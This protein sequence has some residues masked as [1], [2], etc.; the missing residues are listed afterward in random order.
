MPASVSV[1]PSGRNWFFR[2]DF[3]E[4][5]CACL[6]LISEAL[7]GPGAKPTMG[8]KAVIG[9]VVRKRLLV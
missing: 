8:I 5:R 2:V 4:R 7:S 1:V 6:R 3:Q 9:I